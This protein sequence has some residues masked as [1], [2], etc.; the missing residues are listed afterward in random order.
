MT[1]AFELE[2]QQAKADSSKTV[3]HLAPIEKFL[4]AARTALHNDKMQ[5]RALDLVEP[6]SPRAGTAAARHA[7]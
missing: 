3:E 4:I 6:H 2:L 7:S 5:V 1:S